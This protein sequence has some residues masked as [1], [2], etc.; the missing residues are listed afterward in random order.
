M[1]FFSGLTCFRG[2]C[3]ALHNDQS[4]VADS[5][6]QAVDNRPTIICRPLD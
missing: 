5:V 6:Q 2:L 1:L 3:G 4:S